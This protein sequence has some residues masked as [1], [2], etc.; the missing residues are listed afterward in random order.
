MNGRTWRSTAGVMAMA[1]GAIVAA[2]VVIS[3]TIR[4]TVAPEASRIAVAVEK[5]CVRGFLRDA[6]TVAA[7]DVSGTRSAGESRPCR[8]EHH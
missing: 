3:G 2:A 1:G 8:L 7:A 5:A 4:L 6:Q